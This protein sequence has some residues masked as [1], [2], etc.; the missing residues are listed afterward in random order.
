MAGGALLLMAWS[1]PTSAAPLDGLLNASG[2]YP[3]A[4]FFL[5]VGADVMNGNLDFLRVRANDKRL[6]NTLAGDYNGSHIAGGIQLTPGLWL[7]GSYRD[8]TIR[9]VSDPYHYNSGKVALQYRFF[10][11]QAALPALAARLSYWGNWSDVVASSTPV[12]VNKVV[13]T[14]AKIT[15][16]SDAQ[17]QADLIGTWDLSPSTSV[18]LLAGGGA[19]QL[20]Y[21]ALSA[22]TKLNGCITDLAFNRNSIHGQCVQNG[23]VQ[24]QFFDSSGD[25]GIDLVKE[26]A[27]RGAFAQVGANVRWQYGDVTL[28]AAYLYFGIQRD[29][30]DQIL[31]SRGKKQYATNDVLTLDA[32][33][34]VHKHLSLY[35]RS[36]FMTHLFFNDIP[37]MYNSS[38]SSNF[39]R[40]YSLFSFGLRSSF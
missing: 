36:E 3:D 39:S 22:T 27:W 38:S 37:V 11:G 7:T 29:A 35:G 23:V 31:A 21:G 20:H 10:D 9:D 32:D 5:E 19:T 24:S 14:S 18:T 33:Y 30:V 15:Y 6:A 26:L 4:S 8:R 16:P 1:L 25:Y 40:K 34:R 2:A 28:R 13:L 17:L 12:I